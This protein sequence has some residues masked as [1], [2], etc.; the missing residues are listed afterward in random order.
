MTANPKLLCNFAAD[1]WISKLYSEIAGSS[2]PNA[3]FYCFP[4]FVPSPSPHHAEFSTKYSHLRSAAS[5]NPQSS[6]EQGHLLHQ[7]YGVW[8]RVVYLIS[9]AE[10]GSSRHL[11]NKLHGV[12]SQ[13][14]IKFTVTTTRSHNTEQSPAMLNCVVTKQISLPLLY[15]QGKRY[16]KGRNPNPGEA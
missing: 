15:G 6:Y 11:S 1:N 12:T 13:N 5:R 16:K 9:Y 14:K 4:P 3:I 8:R 7:F 2:S 10:D